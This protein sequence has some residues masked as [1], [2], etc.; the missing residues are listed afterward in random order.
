MFCKEEYVIH[1]RN[2]KHALNHSLL[3][4]KVHIF[5]IFTK[6]T[7]FN[8]KSWL[9]PYVNMNAEL[10]TEAENNSEKTVHNEE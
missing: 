3:L 9:K 2:L 6:V 4:K 10:K 7:I 8:Q 5:T 1:I